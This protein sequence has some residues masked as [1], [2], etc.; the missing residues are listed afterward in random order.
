MTGVC[1]MGDTGPLFEKYSQH[2]RLPGRSDAP[3]EEYVIPI[4][5][6]V[7]AETCFAEKLKQD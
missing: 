6:I 1:G 3:L 5:R 7:M 4:Q 2:R